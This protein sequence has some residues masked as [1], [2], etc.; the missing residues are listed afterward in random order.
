MKRFNNK[1]VLR[2]YFYP[3]M[4]KVLGYSDQPGVRPSIDKSLLSSIHLL[5][6]EMFL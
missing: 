1:V 2:D 6:F 3:P 5:P 4:D